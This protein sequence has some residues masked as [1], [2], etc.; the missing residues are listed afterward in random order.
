[1]SEPSVGPPFFLAQM[2]MAMESRFVLL[3]TQVAH[4]TPQGLKTNTRT[5]IR[6]PFLGTQ[7]MAHCLLTEW[8]MN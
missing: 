5:F 8:G 7:D 3:L 2:T 1:M 6:G 4:E